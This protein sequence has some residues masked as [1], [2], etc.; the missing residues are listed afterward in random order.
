MKL[1]NEQSAWDSRW[2]LAYRAMSY[3]VRTYGLSEMAAI[4]ELGDVVRECRDRL[5][6][7]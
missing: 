3:L 6:A 4:Q 5:A 2:K 1:S 7:A